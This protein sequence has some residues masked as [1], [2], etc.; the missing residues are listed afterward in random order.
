MQDNDIDTVPAG[1]SDA[2]MTTEYRKIL[3]D[4]Y[5][6]LTIRDGDTLNTRDGR[7]IK[8]DDAVHLPPVEPTKII[9]VHLNYH[10]RVYSECGG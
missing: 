1:T 8:F 4:G 7:S 9:C 2:A 6:I 3:L 5:P 10:S